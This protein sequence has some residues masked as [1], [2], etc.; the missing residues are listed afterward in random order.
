MD[1]V[2][3]RIRRFILIYR[4]RNNTCTLEG[5]QEFIYLHLQS[6]NLCIIYLAH[7]PVDTY[8]NQRYCHGRQRS[9]LCAG[10][11]AIAWVA[12]WMEA[13]SEA[14]VTL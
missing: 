14:K 4:R 11:A 6:G 10:T 5:S 2:D 8:L 1:R 7:N 12:D 3:D 9:T 13:M